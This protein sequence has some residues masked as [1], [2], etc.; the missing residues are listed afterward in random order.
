MKKQTKPVILKNRSYFT[1][2]SFLVVLAV[3]IF[4]AI[5]VI[6]KKDYEV[7]DFPSSQKP[8]LESADN[9]KHLDA[10]NKNTHNVSYCY[11][12]VYLNNMLLFS[13]MYLS[14]YKGHGFRESL[15]VLHETNFYD[16]YLD[17]V[18]QYLRTLTNN[19]IVISEKKIKQSFGLMKLEVL[20]KYA[21]TKFQDSS[22]LSGLFNVIMFYKKGQ[23]ALDSGG[24]EA[25]IER[26]QM[27]IDH[28]KIEEAY[29]LI[30][31]ITEPEYQEITHPWLKKVGYFIRIKEI[32]EDTKQYMFSERYSRKFMKVCG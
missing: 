3:L 20:R 5:Y 29:A 7:I 19:N 22:L 15:N 6:L 32:L 11:S 2:W 25:K 9:L 14:F 26:A 1:K 23:A 13:D 24:I 28:D 8:V 30:I 18:V 4:V 12:G 21:K 16:K 17:Q 10:N 31:T 27:A